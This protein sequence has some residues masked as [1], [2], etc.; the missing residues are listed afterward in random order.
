MQGRDGGSVA[1]GLDASS[2]LY[3]QS[4]LRSDCGDGMRRHAWLHLYSAPAMA[5]EIEAW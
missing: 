3:G 5:I 2:T 1:V 4:G